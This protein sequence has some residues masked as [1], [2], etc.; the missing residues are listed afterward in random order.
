[1]EIEQNPIKWILSVDTTAI[2][3][4]NLPTW[5]DGG[6]DEVRKPPIT[7][8]AEFFYEIAENFFTDHASR[9]R[10]KCI[11]TSS[12]FLFLKSS[13]RGT[14]YIMQMRGKKGKGDGER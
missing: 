12:R 7:H 14:V 8:H 10:S 4:I 13:A 3:S 11:A 5:I 2:N 9:K 6:K 1:M